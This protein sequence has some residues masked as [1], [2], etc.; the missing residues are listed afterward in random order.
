MTHKRALTRLIIMTIAG[1]AATM[2]TVQLA[3]PTATAAA[4]IYKGNGYVTGYCPGSPIDSGDNTRL[5]DSSG[6][7]HP[8]ATIRLYYS[9]LN[10]GTNCA[11]VFDNEAGSHAM[12]AHIADNKVQES[13]ATDS[14]TFSTYAGGVAITHMNHSCVAWSGTI[15]DNGVTYSGGGY[16]HCA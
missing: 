14:G 10:G 4:P 9:T 12:L 5:Y 7:V 3:V 8:T 16:G 15:D 1:A 13:F 2:S 6:R 11:M